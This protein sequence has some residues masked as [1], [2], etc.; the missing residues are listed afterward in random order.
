M[1]GVAALRPRLPRLCVNSVDVT[2]RE[3]QRRPHDR[4]DL[5]RG[6]AR[7]LPARIEEVLW[8]PFWLSHSHRHT[9]QLEN[10]MTDRGFT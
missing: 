7:T 6:L 10:A 4:Y 8:L 5:S 3:E 2:P 9:F 1:E